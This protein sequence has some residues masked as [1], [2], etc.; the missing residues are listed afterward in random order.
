MNIFNFNYT[1]CI[2]CNSKLIAENNSYTCFICMNYINGRICY[3]N[4]KYLSITISWKGGEIFKKGF[5]QTGWEQIW[6][7][8]QQYPSWVLDENWKITLANG[9]LIKVPFDGLKNIKS[10]E[11]DILRYK[12]LQ[13]FL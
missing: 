3:T 10:L 9:Q 11:Q 13:V 6:P 8:N 7:I 5:C 4:K 12:K 1:T 2:Y